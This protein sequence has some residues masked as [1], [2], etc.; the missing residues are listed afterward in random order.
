MSVP[1]KLYICVCGCV[2]NRSP[3][4]LMLVIRFANYPDQLGR[5][6]EFVKNSTKIK[7]TYGPE[8]GL[9]GPKHVVHYIII[10]WTN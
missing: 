2:Y 10:L 3:R 6:D 9:I 1:Y 5:C 4:I 7:L 8:D